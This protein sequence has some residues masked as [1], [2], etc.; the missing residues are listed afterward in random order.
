MSYFNRKLNQIITPE[1]QLKG[2]RDC[3][4]PG[5]H[6]IVLREGH[7]GLLTRVYLAERD[8]KLN[9]NGT[10]NKNM[11]L[12]IHGHRTGIRITGLLG[13]MVNHTYETH[14]GGNG[15]FEIERCTYDSKIKGGS[16]TLIRGEQTTLYRAD[17]TELRP[18]SRTWMEASEL[19]TV[20]VPMGLRA[21]WLIDEYPADAAHDPSCYTMNPEYSPEGMYTPMDHTECLRLLGQ[22]G[23]IPEN[24]EVK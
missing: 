12:G 8:H 11:T 17:S 24:P 5:L 2:I 15:A 3:H 18:W 23:Y 6:S 7:D 13:V 1:T 22:F 19:H 16:G 4:V 20:W 9:F 14:P 21:S 10:P